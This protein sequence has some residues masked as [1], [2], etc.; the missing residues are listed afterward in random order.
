M[1]MADEDTQIGKKEKIDQ[2]QIEEEMKQDAALEESI[3]D[4]NQ[5]D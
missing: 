2:S 5:D 3:I 1:K 4:D